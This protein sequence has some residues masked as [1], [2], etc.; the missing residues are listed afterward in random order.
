MKRHLLLI[1]VLAI[2]GILST[3]ISAIAQSSTNNDYDVVQLDKWSRYNAVEGEVIV[4]FADG[5]PL[6]ILNDRDGKFQQ[7]GIRAVDALFN[8]LNASKALNVL[9]VER[10]LPNENPNRTLKTTPC[11]NGPDVVERDLSRLCLVKIATPSTENSDNPEDFVST[12]ELIERLKELPEVEF[13]EPNYIAY[14]LGMEKQ[15]TAANA[16]THSGAALPMDGGDKLGGYHNT[17]AY[18]LNPYYHVQW[19]IHATGLND[20]WSDDNNNNSERAVI[21]ILDTG[22]DITHTDLEANI[23]TNPGESDDNN[24]NDNNGFVDDLHGWDFVNQT[25]D[26][27]D[28]NIH[29]THCAGIAAA[30]G[31]NYK[32]IVGANPKAYIM[33]VTVLQSNGSGAVSTIIQ[34]INYAKNNGADV[35]SMSLGTYA[36]SIALEQALGQAYQ[37]C[38]L[39]AAAGNDGASLGPTCRR[40]PM[41]PI[42]PMYP[43]AFTFV[44]GVQSTQAAPG[45]CGYMACYSNYDCDGG[46]FSGYGEE[47]LYNYEIMAPGTEMI[48]TIPNGKY[49]YLNGTSM[50]TPLVAGGISALLHAKDYPSQEMLWGDLINTAS[51]IT[52]NVNFGACYDAGP[53]PAQLQMVAFEMNDTLGGDGDYRPDAGETVAFYPTIR[54]T[55]GAADDIEFWIEFDEYEDPTTLEFLDDSHVDFGHSLSAYAKSKAANP[56]RFKVNENVVDGRYINLVFKATCPNAQGTLS[57]PF[58]IQVENG[59]ELKGM[60]RENTTLHANVHYIVTDNLAVPDGV[61]LKIEPG[62]VLKFKDGVKFSCAGHLSAIGEPDNMITFTK[63]D[64][65]NDWGGLSLNSGDTLSYCIISNISD[66]DGIRG[67]YTVQTYT[68]PYIIGECQENRWCWY[69]YTKLNNLIIKGCNMSYPFVYCAISQSNI[70]NNHGPNFSSVLYYY[71]CSMTCW[72]SD[73]IG[74]PISPEEYYSGTNSWYLNN[75]T[76]GNRN[77]YRRNLEIK[78]LCYGDFKSNIFSNIYNCGYGCSDEQIDLYTES[79]TPFTVGVDESLYLGSGRDDII[80][81][82]IYDFNYPQSGTFGD[83]DITNIGRRP[84]AGAHGIV[85]KVVVTPENSD[86][87]Y[88]A[89]DDFEQMPPL[90]IGRHKFEVYFNRAMDKTTAPMIAMGVRP[91]YTQHSISAD[92]SWNDAGDIYTAYLNLDASM[93]TDGLNRIYVANAKDDEF[94]EIPLENMRFNVQ[95][96]TAGSMSTGFEATPGIG[97]V[98]LTWENDSIYFNDHLGY[99]M[100]RYQVNDRGNS[101]TLLLNETLITELTFTD[102]NVTPGER[103]YY[104]Y[105]DMRTDLS[106]SDPSRNVSTIPLTASP[107]DANGSL[108][109]DVSDIVTIVNYITGE[110]PQPFIFGAADVNNDGEVDVLDIVSVINIINT[111]KYQ[112]DTE[113]TATAVYSITDGILYVDTPVELAGVQV[114][115][116]IED[117]AEIEPLSALNDFEQVGQRMDDGRY[118][119]LAFS[120]AGKKL[121]AGRHALLR[122]GSANVDDMVLSDL[123]GGGVLAVEQANTGVAE[124]NI[125]IINRPYPNPFNG[126]VTIPYII[127]ESEGNVTFTI[128]S[129]TGQQVA[130]FDFGTQSRGEYTF[131]WQPAAGITNGVYIIN[132]V[133][134]GVEVQRNKVVYMR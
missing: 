46:S 119:F 21:A 41:D 69:K 101:D 9:K 70:I 5:T 16:E 40:S 10:L 1:A 84:V 49:K 25:G 72:N 133:V 114:F 58:T 44:L 29:G 130:T 20:L 87:G 45:E 7:T 38:V 112:A 92:G 4:K 129:I 110:N 12:Y 98:D 111:G 37:S 26:I 77:G 43:G 124:N 18:A 126:S 59:V 34:G 57:Y 3:N 13:A 22:V 99:N 127:G 107:G 67:N 11:Y 123:E 89:Q 6:D 19:G 118:M 63:T 36:Y 80:R 95:V 42:S 60:I 30:V 81:Q 93:A 82:H 106:E 115:F 90:G 47:Q 52:G 51:P 75:N 54:T 100:Y 61:T 128:N 23:W 83:I 68:G 53:A 88:D 96:A 117:D 28:F 85:W 122:I 71:G 48:S 86:E 102:Y 105:R 76:I 103:Y 55:W 50:A 33:P 97:K 39:V 65:G 73:G 91:P 131:D 109:V 120:M 2:A 94:F 17:I 79:S 8:D 35:I 116:N 113:L 14:A 31:D 32:G 66:Y 108:T 64:L 132:M 15:P 27:H 56:F 62:T 24:D 125:Y 134:N 121:E 104:F 78:D 74:S